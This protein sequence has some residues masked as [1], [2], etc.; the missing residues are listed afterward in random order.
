MD[1]LEP[2]E[3]EGS[4]SAPGPLSPPSLGHPLGDPYAPTAPVP[5]PRR[6]RLIQALVATAVVAGIAGAAIG[7]GVAEGSSGRST[8]T[9]RSAARKR[10]KN[11]VTNPVSVGS[12]IRTSSR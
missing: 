2:I 6:R 8:L 10:T 11:P 4:S 3:P 7:I 9:F 5:Q 12:G 1:V